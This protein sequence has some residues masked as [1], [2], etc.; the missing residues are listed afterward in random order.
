MKKLLGVFAAVA[1]LL[2][3]IGCKQNAGNAGDFR[4]NYK[5][6]VA[7]FSCERSEDCLYG[8]YFYKN[9]TFK[10][11]FNRT[12]IRDAKEIKGEK[13]SVKVAI[14]LSFLVTNSGTYEGNPLTDETINT[15]YNKKVSTDAF[16]KLID[17]KT[18]KAIKSYETKETP[19]EAIEYIK[20][21]CTK[22]E[23]DVYLLYVYIKS[24]EAEYIT[25]EEPAVYLGTVDLEKAELTIATEFTSG[26]APF[27][28]EYPK[29]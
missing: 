14:A 1:V 27:R 20:K 4:G 11:Y 26:P 21:N 18:S 5:N 13:E 8:I 15:V 3:F 25:L 29:D 6:V 16:S 19:E 17:D 28:Q 9:G 22:T 7:A 2:S 23:D 12:D 24:N 10:T